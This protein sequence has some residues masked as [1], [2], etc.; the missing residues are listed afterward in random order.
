MLSESNT[1]LRCPYGAPTQRLPQSAD[2]TDGGHRLTSNDFGRFR[3][4]SSSLSH[5]DATL[6]RRRRHLSSRSST[7][8]LFPLRRR[9]LNP[10]VSPSAATALLHNPNAN[11]NAPLVLPPSSYPSY[12]TVDY[13]SLLLLVHERAFSRLQFRRRRRPRLRISYDTH[14][15]SDPLPFLVRT[16]LFNSCLLVSSHLLS[17]PCLFIATSYTLP[18]CIPVYCL[19]NHGSFVPVST[20]VTRLPCET[21]LCCRRA[22]TLQQFS[23]SSI[24]LSSSL[25]GLSDRT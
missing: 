5:H 20:A 14:L 16:F 18:R 22:E 9:P 1:H 11:F 8:A 12:N 25:P 6:L 7:N 3:S 19:Q 2:T 21:R 24:T 13:L 4:C 23:K 17:P 15:A 10:P